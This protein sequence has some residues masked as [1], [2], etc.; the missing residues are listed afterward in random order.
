LA[1]VPKGLNRRLEIEHPTG[2]FTV[3]L[4]KNTMDEPD[5]SARAALL[6]TARLIMHGLVQIPVAVWDGRR[7][8]KH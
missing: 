4:S 6:R 2:E 5:A 8:G 7:G 3:Q 1:V